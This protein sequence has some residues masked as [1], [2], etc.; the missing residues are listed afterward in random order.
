VSFLC[1][2]RGGGR[3]AHHALRGGAV[4][5]HEQR[6]G[7][8]LHIGK[9]QSRPYDTFGGRVERITASPH[10]THCSAHDRSLFTPSSSSGPLVPVASLTLS[11]AGPVWCASGHLVVWSSE[12]PPSVSTRDSLFSTR[13]IP[14]HDIFVLGS[15]GVSTRG[16]RW[17]E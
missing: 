14:I 16:R 15:T 7:A 5:P 11:A 10:A 9:L 13:S 1:V 3:G 6:V 17:R 2:T 4:I 8:T 12:S